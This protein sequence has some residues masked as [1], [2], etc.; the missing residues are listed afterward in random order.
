M[1]NETVS[2]KTMNLGMTHLGCTA[3]LTVAL[4]CVAAAG[5]PVV[6]Q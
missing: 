2:V 1:N 5:L 6:I 3:E 4:I